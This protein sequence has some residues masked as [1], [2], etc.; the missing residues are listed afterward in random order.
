M[1]SK[2]ESFLVFLLSDMFSLL[3][4][5]MME[6]DISSSLKDIELVDSGVD[7]ELELFDEEVVFF[8]FDEDE[9]SDMI[10]NKLDNSKEKDYEFKLIEKEVLD[11][12]EER[13]SNEDIIEFEDFENLGDDLK[14]L[15]IKFF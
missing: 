12:I 10:V 5:R 9:D 1:F 14:E 8:D 7:E 15:V 13:D 11:E 3:G 4:F 6:V 2:V